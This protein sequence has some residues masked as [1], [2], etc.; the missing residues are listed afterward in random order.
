MEVVVVLV[1]RP[2]NQEN[3]HA[4]NLHLQMVDNPVTGK[5]SSFDHVSKQSVLKVRHF[6]SWG[7]H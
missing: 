4:P 1:V 3:E 5:M 7:T 2:Q 6:F